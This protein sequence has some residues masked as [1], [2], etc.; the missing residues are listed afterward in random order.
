MST[1]QSWIPL[2]SSNPFF[3]DCV[4]DGTY[5]LNPSDDPMKN[6]PQSPMEYKI[7]CQEWNHLPSRSVENFT[8]PAG[9]NSLT[10]LKYYHRISLTSRENRIN[11]YHHPLMVIFQSITQCDNRQVDKGTVIADHNSFCS[12]EECASPLCLTKL[13]RYGTS[14]SAHSFTALVP[15]AEYHLVVD[16]TWFVN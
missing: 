15:F 4:A 8:P 14:V 11:S 16:I 9:Y 13:V 5:I 2:L 6:V 7:H 3:D 12:R 1:G 10:Y